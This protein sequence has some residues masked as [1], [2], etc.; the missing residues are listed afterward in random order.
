MRTPLLLVAVVAAACGASSA[1]IK[2]ARDASYQ[3]EYERVWEAV[4]AEISSQYE[5]DRQDPEHG[6]IVT[7]WKKVERTAERSDQGQSAQGALLFAA[8]VT[9]KGGPPWTAYVDGVAGEYRPGMAVLTTYKHGVAD[10]PPWVQ[11]RIDGLYVAIHERLQGN[12]VYG[13]APPPPPEAAFDVT[14]DADIA[15]QPGGGGR[16]AGPPVDTNRM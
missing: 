11:G 10:E 7:R 16:N 3:A 14:G 6:I 9:V 8:K 13:V 1:E 2:K 15:G 4:V 12:A 5:I